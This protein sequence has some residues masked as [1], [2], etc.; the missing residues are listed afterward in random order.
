MSAMKS[1][2][3]FAF[4]LLSLGLLA[5]NKEVNTFFDNGMVKSTYR[6]TNTKNYEVIN[7]YASGKM[8]E[9]GRFVNGKMDGNWTAYAENGVRISEAFYKNGEKSGEWRIYDD[10]GALRYKILYD[11]NRIVSAVNFDANGNSIAETRT[12]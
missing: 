11:A 2:F 9:S 4:S 6:Y 3:V 1:L 7:F 8:M 10:S 12:R 5:Q